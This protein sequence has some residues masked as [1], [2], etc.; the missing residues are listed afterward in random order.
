MQERTRL[1]A[2]GATVPAWSHDII[3]FISV[4]SHWTPEG[5][6]NRRIA[7]YVGR[8]EPRVSEV[9][10]K[11]ERAGILK[12]VKRGKEMLACLN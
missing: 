5:F 3:R 12:R 11:M 2:T 1:V 7:E 9:V 6:S 4:H 8:P 10:R